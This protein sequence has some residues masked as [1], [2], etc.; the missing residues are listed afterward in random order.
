MRR[1][2][3]L[4]TAR[5]R[6]QSAA[7]KPT[8]PPASQNHF[9]STPLIPGTAP[10][11]W[12]R[13]RSNSQ[14]HE[15]CRVLSA[16]RSPWQPTAIFKDTSSPKDSLICPVSPFSTANSPAHRR[17]VPHHAVGVT[18]P[19]TPHLSVVNPCS[20]RRRPLLT[21]TS[22]PVQLTTN[23]VSLPSPSPSRQSPSCSALF[24]VATILVRCKPI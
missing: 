3:K 21:S 22:H 8:S 24:P 19:A 5:A 12:R 2:L 14:T 23:L 20:I 13:R 17:V 9:Q 15:L 10:L 4:Q 11:S 1:R 7:A 18:Q 6:I 16:I